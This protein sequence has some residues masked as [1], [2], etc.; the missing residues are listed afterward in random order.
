MY[1]SSAIAVVITLFTFASADG[2]LT[3]HNTCSQTA[4]LWR[5]SPGV[6]AGNP[7]TIENGNSWVDGANGFS[8]TGVSDQLVVG[9]SDGINH[10]AYQTDVQ[11]TVNDA[12]NKIW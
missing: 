8:G 6:T 11:Y 12:D 2:T 3:F 1:I 4:Y 10:G 7:V 5:V 9:D